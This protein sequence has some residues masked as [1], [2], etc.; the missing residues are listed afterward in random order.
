[1]WCGVQEF[2]IV[3]KTRVVSNSGHFIY[4]FR[5]FELYKDF[6]FSFSLTEQ[7]CFEFC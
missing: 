3:T 7:I 5:C 4:L 2:K 1:M 6:G